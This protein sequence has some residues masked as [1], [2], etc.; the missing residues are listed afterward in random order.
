VIALPN[1]RQ[2]RRATGKKGSIHKLKTEATMHG[3]ALI[4]T[5]RT[6]Q[7]VIWLDNNFTINLAGFG[8]QTLNEA[9]ELP[10]GSTLISPPVAVASGNLIHVFGIGPDHGLYHWVFNSSAR[11]GSQWSPQEL[12][13]LNCFSTPAAVLSGPNQIDLF[14]LG[15]DRGMLHTRWNG[16]KWSTW[17]E[18]GGAFISLPVVLPSAAGFDIFARGLDFMVYHATNWKPGGSA[19]WQLLGGGLLGEPQAAS[20]PAAVRLSASTLVFVTSAAGEIWYTVFEGK[21]WRAWISMGPA[22]QATTRD[23]A[24]TFICEPVPVLHRSDDIGGGGSGAG[25]TTT[26][27]PVALQP[28]PFSI[29]GGEHVAV[30]AV[31]SDNALWQKRLDHD[32]W[33]PSGDWSSLGGS[34]ACAPS[35]V[36]WTPQSIVVTHIQPAHFSLVAPETDNTVHRWNF[37]PTTGPDGTWS[38]DDNVSHPTFRLPCHY[39]FAVDNVH[40]DNTR[41]L[42]NDTDLAIAN[43]KVGNWPLRTISFNMNDVNNGDHPLFQKVAIP[44][45]VELCEPVTFA[46][47]IVN[48]HDSGDEETVTRV[49][50]KG[51]EDYLNDFLKS[52]GAVQGPNLLGSELGAVV[53][54]FADNLVNFAF[55]GC[56]GLVAAKVMPFPTGRDVQEK[57][58][59]FGNGTPRRFT[60][61][62]PDQ[63]FDAPT[64]CRSSSYVVSSSIT[65]S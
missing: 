43:L 49:V 39:T 30:F 32:G 50:V 47:T 1:A 42:H 65:Q 21:L 10:I 53:A 14:A 11:F 4:S 26:T 19:D 23:D 22:Q 45:L 55:G 6:S 25:G 59:D 34:F 57:I 35:V 31:G 7:D 17:E 64:L 48:S 52:G 41:A 28:P 24:V 18:L 20:A 13:G 54:W 8:D 33:H 56:D 37:D 38:R 29:S 16:S 2:K 63:R 27:I 15:P 40:I 58:T 61:S 51:L 9:R 62:I 5:G 44:A 12:V 3:V 60:M 46:Y 36:A